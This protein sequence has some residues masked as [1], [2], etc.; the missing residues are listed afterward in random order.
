MQM[1][2]TVDMTGSKM[3]MAKPLRKRQE[4]KKPLRDATG[5]R[6]RI[7][8]AAKARFC[9]HSYEQVGVREIAADAGIDA[10][11]INRYFGTKEEL[12]AEV[13]KGVFNAEHFIEVAP[14]RLGEALARR[15]MHGTGK[16]KRGVNPFELLLRSA[17]SP[18]AS[19]I[20]GNRLHKDFVLQLAALIGGKQASARAAL[21]ASYIIGFLTVRVALRSPAILPDDAERVVALL[22]AA[23]QA[24]IDDPE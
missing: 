21:I 14:D 22:G 13:S 1:S 16:K 12:F 5:T 6:R 2:T 23:I 15:L 17:A 24:A 20:I 3:A 10:A 8:E 19:P 4:R 7:L 9:K 11:L 18:T